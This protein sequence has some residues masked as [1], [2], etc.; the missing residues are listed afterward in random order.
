MM[1]VAFFPFERW[2]VAYLPG[3][4]V[5]KASFDKLSGVWLAEAVLGL[6]SG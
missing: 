1:T 6:V 2:T 5:Y 4:I 3:V